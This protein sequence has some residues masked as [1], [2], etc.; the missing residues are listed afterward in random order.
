MN[1]S[2]FEPLTL[3]ETTIPNRVMVS[4]MCQYSCDDRDGLATDW[5]HVHL[6]SRAVGGAGVVIAEATAVE[7]RGRISPNDLGIWSDEHAEALRPVTEFVRG[8]GSVPAIQLA[9]A[10]RKGSKTRPWEGSE[11]L[12]PDEG[13]YEVLAP[14]HRPY[15]IDGQPPELR[16]MTEDD[17]ATLV[18]DGIAISLSY[19]LSTRSTAPL[20]VLHLAFAAVLGFALNNIFG[21]V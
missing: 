1:A 11:P 9:H 21:L 13:G 6:G 14:S 4:P 5:H 18:A 10:G 17:V 2:L 19:R 3:R 12:Q 15:P 8:Q 20:V 7:P 16:E